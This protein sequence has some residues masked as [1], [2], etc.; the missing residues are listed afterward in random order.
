MPR[1]PTAAAQTFFQSRERERKKKERENKGRVRQ[2]KRKGGEE[3]DVVGNLSR[4]KVR[5]KMISKERKEREKV[6]N[7]RRKK[8]LGKTLLAYR[9][10]IQFCVFV[11][12]KRKTRNCFAERIVEQL[13]ENNK[14]NV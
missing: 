12:P 3:I 14:L 2:C 4:E 1:R 10:T 11:V 13:Q 7:F 8:S 6:S 5:Q 9:L